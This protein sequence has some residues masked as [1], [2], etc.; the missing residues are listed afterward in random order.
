M[1]SNAILL[2]KEK[3]LAELLKEK[4]DTNANF[5]RPL[6]EF[7]K[8]S[9]P[10]DS[11]VYGCYGLWLSGEGGSCIKGQRIADYYD[12]L[13]FNGIDELKAFAKAY[14]MYLDWNDCGTPVLLFK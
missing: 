9:R 2:K 7:W 14:N 1:K 4:M 5:V 12:P 11:G 3:A 8:G 10:E 13:A 6:S